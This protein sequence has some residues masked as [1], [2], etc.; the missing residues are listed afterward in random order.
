MIYNSGKKEAT[1]NH[2]TVG[3]HYN[4]RFIKGPQHQEG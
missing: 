3:D 4:M 2:F 1:E